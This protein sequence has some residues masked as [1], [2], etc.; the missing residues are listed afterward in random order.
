MQ[1]KKKRALLKLKRESKCAKLLVT[2][3]EV[4]RQKRM[5]V[6]SLPLTQL[7]AA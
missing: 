2:L 1:K 5:K 7:I 6:I 4:L 3:G